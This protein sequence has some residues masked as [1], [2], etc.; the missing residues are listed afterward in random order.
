MVCIQTEHVFSGFGKKCRG[1][2]VI[3]PV[4]EALGMGLGCGQ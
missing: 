3:F 1:Y 4:V 2:G